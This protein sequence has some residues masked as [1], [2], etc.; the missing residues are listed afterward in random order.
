MLYFGIRIFEMQL[1]TKLLMDLTGEKVRPIPFAASSDALFRAGWVA[2]VGEAQHNFFLGKASSLSKLHC[3]VWE[4]F[5][6]RI[7]AL[8]GQESCFI[9]TSQYVR[10]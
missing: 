1:P 2:F 4:C 9:L 8:H 5:C 7:L 6:W 10:C 3:S